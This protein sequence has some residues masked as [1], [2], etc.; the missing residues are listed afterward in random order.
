M[1]IIK[2]YFIFKVRCQNKQKIQESNIFVIEPNA[3]NFAFPVIW[4]F[5]IFIFLR[6]ATFPSENLC[7]YKAHVPL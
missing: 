3:K 5:T 4:C 1:K 6:C 2:L 7:Y